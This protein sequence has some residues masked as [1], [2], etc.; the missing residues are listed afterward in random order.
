MPNHPRLKIAEEKEQEEVTT[1]G[2]TKST[3]GEKP[4]VIGDVSVGDDPNEEPFCC[5]S[6]K[7]DS[8]E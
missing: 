1:K 8:T 5:L 4:E 2:M 7:I 3:V 6:F